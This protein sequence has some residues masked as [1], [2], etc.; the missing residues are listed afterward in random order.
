M[1]STLHAA[2]ALDRRDL[3]EH[4]PGQE[5]AAGEAR[6]HPHPASG[7]GDLPEHEPV[8]PLDELHDALGDRAER[9]ETRDADRDA[10]DRERVAPER[11]EDAPEGRYHSRR[12]STGRPARRQAQVLTRAAANIIASPRRTRSGVLTQ[13]PPDSTLSTDT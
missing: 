11:R 3:L 4:A 5:P 6:A 9:D 7:H 13:L 12:D 2:H 1:P 8:A 10:G